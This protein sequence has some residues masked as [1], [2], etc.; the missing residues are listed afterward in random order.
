[1]AGT[2]GRWRHLAWLYPAATTF[3]VL[4]TA[5]HFVLDAAAGLAVTALGLL[6]S[7][8]QPGLPGRRPRNS[9]P[10]RGGRHLPRRPHSQSRLPP[11]PEKVTAMSAPHKDAP[12]AADARAACSWSAP[13]RPARPGLKP[14]TAHPRA[15]PASRTPQA[16][17]GQVASARSPPGPGVTVPPPGT[18]AAPRPF[19]ARHK[20]RGATV[21]AR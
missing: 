14:A 15:R 17:A 3:V 13:G 2:R 8:T 16:A 10:A 9:R 1:V 4:A 6:A 18:A 19:P 7:A 21:I 5:N 12:A 20:C 11:D